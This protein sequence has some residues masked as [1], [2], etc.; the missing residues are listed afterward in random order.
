[1]ES[2]VIR[3]QG[4]ADSPEVTRVPPDPKFYRILK[5]WRAGMVALTRAS[6]GT[7]LPDCI[8]MD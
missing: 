8:R 3:K 5:I 6:V 2:S 1:M 7:V 4:S